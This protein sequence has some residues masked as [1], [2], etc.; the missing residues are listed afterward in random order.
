[1]HDQS[2]RADGLREQTKGPVPARVDKLSSTDIGRDKGGGCKL[3]H[4]GERFCLFRLF[5][6]DSLTSH[7]EGEILLFTKF[8]DLGI[9][10][11]PFCISAR[12]GGDKKWKGKRS[13]KKL[14]AETHLIIV[15]LR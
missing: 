5:Q 10:C 11:P 8:C 3:S 12:H 6:H 14:S 2:G 15:D 9:D 4:D 7:S 1:M 13:S